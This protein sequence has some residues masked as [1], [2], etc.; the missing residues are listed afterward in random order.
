MP[1]DSPVFDL[2]SGPR[3]RTT[4]PPRKASFWILTVLG[5][6]G[7]LGIIMFNMLREPIP[8]T[9]VVE[10]PPEV[11][12]RWITSD[13]RYEDRGLRIRS[14]DIVL[15]VGPDQPPLRGTI[16]LLS[17][18]QEGESTVIYIEYDAGEGPM[19][20]EIILDGPDRMHLRNPEE[21]TWTRV[22]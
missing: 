9:T 13:P 14:H 19:V 21:V 12:G 15:E 16:L 11:V 20:L 2:S 22:H 17:T 3:H 4:P 18:R 7:I 1:D 10:A 6:A 8:G 5:I